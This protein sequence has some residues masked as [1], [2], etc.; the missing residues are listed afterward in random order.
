MGQ[1]LS[2]TIDMAKY[3]M[4]QKLR[5]RKRYPMV[6]MLE[7]TELCNLTCTG[8]GKIRQSEEILKMRLTAQDCFD[9]IDECGA[10]GVSIA[11]GEPLVHPEIVDIVKGML[12]RGKL[13]MLCTNGILLHRILDKIEPHPRFTFVFHLDGPREHHDR[14]V[15]RKGVFDIV[16][17][18]IEESKRRGFR[19]TTNTT[20]Y[21]GVNPQEIA[22]LLQQ[23][24]EM[25]VDNCLLSPAFTYE[26]VNG[27]NSEIFL[28]RREVIAMVS[29]IVRLAGPKVRY[30]NTPM[31]L[32]FLQGKRDLRCTPWSMPNRNPKGWKGPCY[33]LTDGHYDTFE[34]LMQ[35]TNWDDYGYGKNPRCASCMMHS[36]YEA[37]AVEK[38]SPVDM[39]RMMRWMFAS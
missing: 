20:L 27:A 6:L 14:M 3:V 12:A 2:L 13:T 18:G 39:W 8:C 5:G 37:S 35:K 10:P 34:E 28:H 1:P 19:V 23:L 26:E 36:G 31:F 7:P 16:M 30:Y 29:E 11:G 9:A 4:R 17:K 15:E 33:L 21:K 32:D 25:G 24:T 38:M 22:T